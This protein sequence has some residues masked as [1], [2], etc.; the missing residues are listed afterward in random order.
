MRRNKF[1]KHHRENPYFHRFRTDISDFDMNALPKMVDD[2]KF[3]L[4]ERI[5]PGV[6]GV[7]KHMCGGATDLS[8]NSLLKYD[9]SKIE[10]KGV[11]IATCCHH[12]CTVSLYTNAR[13]LI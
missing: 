3:S 8:I 11:F 5:I 10:L 12:R 13:L 9:K 1:D 7:A 4:G 6:V 2:L